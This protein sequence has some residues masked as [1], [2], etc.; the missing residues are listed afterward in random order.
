M[1]AIGIVINNNSERDNVRE[2]FEHNV[3]TLHFFPDGIGRFFTAQY[4]GFHAR[5]VHYV[6]QI[7]DDGIHHTATL[8]AQEIKA[9]QN[10][11][12]RF[13]VKNRKR[14]ILQL[15][16]HLLDPHTLG[17]RRID[18]E[19][20]QCFEPLLFR[21]LHI[22][23]GAHVMQTVSKLHQ[24]HANIFGHRHNQ[25]AEIFRLLGFFALKL[26]T[27]ELGHAFYHMRHFRAKH[28]GQL[29]FSRAGIFN[30][31]MQQRRRYRCAIQLHLGQ[32]ASH[33]QRV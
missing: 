32:N 8:T 30:R 21:L 10:T 29:F 3:F 13:T 14:Q 33:F 20:L 6:L 12:T 11:V 9:R 27:R 19:S 17:Q 22:M 1:I 15:F 31:V 18:F 5:C 23:N 25:F 16:L 24:Q 28:V 2:L 7:T 4:F 26:Q